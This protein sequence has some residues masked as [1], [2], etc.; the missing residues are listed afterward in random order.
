MTNKQTRT[1]KFLYLS[2]CQ[3]STISQ[4][5]GYIRTVIRLM[6]LVYEIVLL[7]VLGLKV[8]PPAICFLG[9]PAASHFTFP[10]SSYDIL[11]TQTVLVASVH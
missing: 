8:F 7:L 2:R 1:I 4:F 6:H 9:S 10:S 3:M 5:L 11:T